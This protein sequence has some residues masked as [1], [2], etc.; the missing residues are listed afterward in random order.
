MANEVA[1]AVE[2]GGVPEQVDAIGEITRAEIDIQIA[3][4]K[5]FPRV[6]S[7]FKKDALAMATIDEETAEACRYV[8]P[9]GGEAIEGPS[10]RFAEICGTAWGN[11]RYGAR[12][13]AIDDKH[14]T[15]QGVCHDLE[16]NVAM[17]IEV[18]RRIT[19]KQGRRF[20]DDMIQVTANAACSIALRNAIFKVVPAAL[21]KGIFD[22]TRK[23][24]IGNE[25]SLDVRR[26][27]A[28]K[29]FEAKGAE[30]HKLLKLLDC[31]SVEDISLDHLSILTGL[32]TAI[33]D[34][35]TTIAEVF[36]RKDGSAID[37]DALKSGGRVSFGKRKAKGDEEDETENADKEASDDAGDSTGPSIEEMRLKIAGL[38]PSEFDIVVEQLGFENVGHPDDLDDEQVAQMHAEIEASSP[39]GGGDEL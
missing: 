18:K 38:K 17:T 4:A 6:L 32:R 2:A 12:V 7:E 24:A 1:K 36:D 28:V 15:A 14:V 22:E 8:L 9:R 20:S 31:K 37:L 27:A 11:V 33:N 35:D 30:K 19:N 3:T 13:V 26:N 39:E 25:R 34:G 23:V 5:R 21:T 29:W 16:K 10:V